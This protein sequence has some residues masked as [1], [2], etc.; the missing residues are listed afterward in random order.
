MEAFFP[1]QSDNNGLRSRVAGT[2]GNLRGRWGIVL[3][4]PFLH[5]YVYSWEGR[6]NNAGE[7]REL[8][9]LTEEKRTWDSLQLLSF[10]FFLFQVERKVCVYIQGDESGKQCLVHIQGICFSLVC[11]NVID[12]Q[13]AFPQFISFWPKHKSFLVYS[14][15]FM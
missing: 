11:K 10:S 14:L 15:F 8:P 9:P 4:M 2:T 13:V 5:S 3:Q 7:P 1:V 6:E 12:L